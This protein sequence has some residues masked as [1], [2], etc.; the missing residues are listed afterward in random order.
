MNNTYFIL[1]HGQNYHQVEKPEIIYPWPETSPI[2]LTKKGIKDVKA[3]A[4][5]LKLRNVDIIYSSDTSRARQT[6][7]I[8]AKE[9]KVK[10]VLDSRLRDINLGIYNSK[11]K[12]EYKHFLSTQK[13][14]F[15]KR[16]P[17]GESWN[18]VKKRMMNF[19]KDIDEKHK[20]K[21]IL[22]VSH[23]DPFWLL[24][25]TIKGLNEEKLWEQKYKGLFLRTSQ[26]RKL[27]K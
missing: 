3:V 13:Q 19:F 8:V 23:G 14:R 10:V 20:N 27:K 18:D 25:G 15:S 21:N 7:K 4:K 26:L 1:R 2:L 22:I 24:E 5:R 16:P 11:S 6:A 12:K 17:Q 9:I